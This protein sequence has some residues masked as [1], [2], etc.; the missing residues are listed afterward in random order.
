MRRYPR[1]AV[2]QTNRVGFTL[3]ELLVVIAIIG[4]LV[5]LLLPAVQTAREAARRAQCLNNCRQVAIACH[6]YH[7]ANGRL[8]PGYGF[9]A[10]PPGAG[11]A[12]E[13]EWP[14]C[15]RL[16]PFMEEG[17][18][19]VTINFS[20]NPG[21]AITE[22]LPAL[23][24]RIPSFECPS[25]EFVAKL[26]NRDGR[27]EANEKRHGRISYGGNFGRGQL[28]APN[29]VAGVFGHN[30]GAAFREIA[31]GT[32]NTLL[33]AELINGQ[34]CTV[35]GLHTYDEGPVVMQDYHPNDPTP[36][37][38][39]WCD[40][41][42]SHTTNR[43]APC[44]HASGNRGTLS[45]LNMIL[46]TARSPHPGGVQ[47]TFCDASARFISDSLDLQ[48]WQAIGTPDGEEIATHADL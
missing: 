9:F 16:W 34:G 26:W 27:C 15:P 20:L 45:K 43:Q 11:V 44:L 28:E 10:S 35:R 42:D 41:K 33:T 30:Y 19:T 2:L 5:A 29:R 17:A 21:W 46:H 1:R 22:I 8:P 12:A 7:G 38:V 4:I 39:R 48:V 23:R 18:A 31:D 6:N 13:P 32:S 36:D 37:L 14:W 24:V 3:V 47:V 40:A 25:D